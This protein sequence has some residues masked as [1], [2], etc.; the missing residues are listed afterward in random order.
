MKIGILGTGEVGQ[1][2]GRGFAALR[3]EVKMGSRSATNAKALAWAKRTGPPA[4]VGTFAAAAAFGE[5]VVL[6]TLGVANESVLQ[7]AGPEKLRGKIVIDATNPLDF[8][9]GVPPTLAIAGHDSGGEQ[10]QRLLPGAQV[11]KAFNTVGHAHMFRPD[12]PDGPPDM[13]LCGDD[14][15]AKEKVGE[16]LQNFGWGVVDIGGI[17]GSRYLEAM[18]LVWVRYAFSTPAPTWNHAFRLLKK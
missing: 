9:R 14:A 17:D 7:A 11:V 16:L 12:F 6:A 5:I 10:V 18:C 3:H 8:S 2:L 4:S 13:F 15:T 1:A